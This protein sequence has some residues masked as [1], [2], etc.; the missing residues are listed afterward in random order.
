MKKTIKIFSAIALSALV[1]SSCIKETMPQSDYATSEQLGASASA[2]EAAMS[3]LPAQLTQSY[4]ILGSDEQQ[5][6]DIAYPSFMMMYSEMLG[7]IYPGGSNV[8]YDWFRRFNTNESQGDAYTMI[9]IPWRA[10]YMFIKSANDIIGSVDEA[11]ATPAIKAYAGMAYVYR[12]FW[13]YHAMNLYEPKANPY[14]D[15]SN[16]LGLTVPIVKEDTPE[17]AGKNNPRASHAEMVSFILSDLDKAQEFL[18]DYTPTT[19]M[20]P[21]LAVAY[22]V[23]AKV[24]MT[25][26]QYKEA[27]K[28]ARMAID[29]FGGTPVTQSQWLDV[30]TGFVKANQAWMWYTSYS[31]ETMGNLANWIGWAS[32]EADWGYSSLTCPMIDK[33][34]YDRISYSDF[35]KYT[36][37][38]PDRSVF[39]YQTC[40]ESGWIEKQVDYLSIKFRCV[41]GDFETYTVGGVCDVPMMRVEEMYYIEAEATGLSEGV[42]AGVA[43]LN[44]FV[45]TY[46]QPNYNCTAT[47]VADFEDEILFQKRVEFWGEGIALFDA[48]RMG[49]G[50]HQ[51]YEGTNAPGD[52]FKLNCDVIKPNWNMVIPRTEVNNNNALQGFNNPDPTGTVIPDLTW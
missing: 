20:Y 41:D 27:A 5:E 45:K 46:R 28:Y 17:S 30:N 16:V 44:N 4:P 21:S 13:Y 19:K 38:D 25:D 42:P 37:L 1:L 48:K 35:R 31:A 24:L 32:G 29:A 18:A 36:F 52:A 33:A 15:V 2:L 12:A 39:N 51:S 9:Y 49:A 34:L 6:T 7:D 8:G 50:C 47:S 26:G 3:G 23:R 10:L 14:T 40:R 11:T 22:G 43:L